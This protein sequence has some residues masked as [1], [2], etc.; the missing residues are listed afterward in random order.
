MRLYYSPERPQIEGTL[1]LSA[2]VMSRGGEPLQGGDVTARITAPSG[3]AE[4]IGFASSAD[5]WGAYSAQFIAREPGKHQVVLRCK[6][7]GATLEASFFVQGAAD[8]P[9]GRPARPE[10]LEEIAR[11]TRGKLLRIEQP[12]AIVSSLAALPDPAPATRRLQLWSHPVTAGLLI[13]LLGV[14]WV[15]RKAA[16]LI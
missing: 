11:V 15:G 9:V 3:K 5:A 14:F 13:T 16:G 12:E 7:T 10:V 6:Q 1:S 2:N 8:E 4:T